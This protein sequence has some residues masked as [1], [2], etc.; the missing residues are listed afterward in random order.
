[1]ARHIHIRKRDRGSD[2]AT[3]VESFVV[4][5]G[6]GGDCLDDFDQLRAD[7]GLASILGHAYLRR[8]RRGIFRMSS[9]RRAASTTPSSSVLYWERRP[10]FLV[11]TRR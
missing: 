8:E 5:N 9:R 1:M 4:R 6:V 10:I 2:E 3:F 11:R 7:A